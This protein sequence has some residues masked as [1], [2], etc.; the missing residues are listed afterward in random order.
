MLAKNEMHAACVCRDYDEL[1]VL[2]DCNAIWHVGRMIKACKSKQCMKI[3]KPLSQ[4]EILQ[5][6]VTNMELIMPQNGLRAV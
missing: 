6:S 2:L 4:C 1:K 5:G 3:F